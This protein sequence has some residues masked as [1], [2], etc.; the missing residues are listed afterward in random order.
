MERNGKRPRITLYSH[1]TQGLGHLRRNLRIAS[2]LANSHLSPDILL[3]T[4]AREVAAFK[5]PPRTDCLVLP[6][7]GKQED[8]QYHSRSLTI[9]LST[10]VA[11]RA[12]TIQAA[13]RSF[14]PHILIAD[15][16]PSGAFG[17]LMPALTA[18]RADGGT[19][20]VLGL[21]DVLDDPAV[22][23]N[24]W[25]K[26][27]SSAVVRSYYDAVW[28]YGDQAVYDPV[29]EYTLNQDVAAKVTFT[30]YIGVKNGNEQ[31]RLRADDRLGRA[32]QSK[33][34]SALC[35]LGGGQDGYELARSFAQAQLPAGTDGIIVTGPFM[36]AE[37][38]A[39]LRDMIARRPGFSMT[40]FEVDLERLMQDADFVV[41]MGG[42]NTVCEIL[43][44]EKRALIVPRVVPRKEQL[45]R[46]IRLSEL[47]LLD[48]L[49]P[50]RLSPNKLSEWL[51]KNTKG[52]P[53]TNRVI[54]LKGLARVLRLTVQMLRNHASAPS[55]S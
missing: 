21:R 24:E 50:E 7:L 41:S 43:S 22:V 54:D 38:T 2:T 9:P 25:K 28:I 53:K 26:A 14:K 46:A 44:Y 27:N 37:D 34:R 47:G 5:L 29:F 8:G 32:V 11:L 42:Y 16:V 23:A 39:N 45:I 49:Q 35:L 40:G 20:C 10:S 30:G 33:S 31:H 13:L 4:G 6:G 18:L 55:L 19:Q 51:S 52:R 36:S 48:C 12:N 1:D 3:I 15:K 17:E